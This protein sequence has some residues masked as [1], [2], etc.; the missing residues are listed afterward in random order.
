MRNSH[1]Q[2]NTE[3]YACKRYTHR[4]AKWKNRLRKLASSC[5]R[6]V[7]RK[8]R[9]RKKREKERERRVNGRNKTERESDRKRQTMGLM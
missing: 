9:E 4:E 2:R 1:T 8:E 6:E 3:T 7:G 5:M